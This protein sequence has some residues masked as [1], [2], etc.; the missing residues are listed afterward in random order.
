[1]DNIQ[2]ESVLEEGGNV[3]ASEVILERGALRRTEEFLRSCF[4][5]KTPLLIADPN[6][7]RAAGQAVRDL[8]PDAETLVLDDPG[9]YAEYRFLEEV[10]AWLRETPGV[11]VAVGSGT[12]N[13]LTKLAAHRLERP[14]AAIATAASMDGY[15]AF[16]ASITYRG[17]K[18][19][20]SCAPPELV[21]A[22][23][24]VLAAAPPELSAAGYA[25]LQ[26]KITAGADWILADALGEDSIHPEGWATVQHPL[27]EALADPAGVRSGDPEAIRRLM[28]GL[29]AGGTAMLVTQTSR[30]ASGAEH[31]FSHLWDMEGH[32]H[33]G[34]TP[35]HGF[36]VG[37][38]TAAVAELYERLL[39]MPLEQ[40]DADALAA[41]WPAWEEEEAESVAFAGL[42]TWRAWRRRRPRASGRRARN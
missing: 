8:L 39:E 42:A 14:Y 35:A 10:E 41:K 19:T 7:W 9:L 17:N 2:A 38:A 20:F 23:L 27:R 29:L 34:K 31:Q 11:P 36:K 15:T 13:D 4:P 40:L 22:D 16:G 5:G 6:T 26:A 21:V 25:D 1:M 30:P 24:D 33:R 37:I 3:R 28:N 32:R 12:L 18:Q